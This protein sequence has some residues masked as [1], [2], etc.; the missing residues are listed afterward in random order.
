MALCYLR[1]IFIQWWC[2]EVSLLTL[3]IGIAM[4]GSVKV[5]A[6]IPIAPQSF[7]AKTVVLANPLVERVYS[8]VSGGEL[9]LTYQLHPHATP[10]QKIS[11]DMQINRLGTQIN[12]FI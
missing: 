9:Y 4:E 1:G 2:K 5:C 6:S 3:F 7:I 10:I 11:V 8:A 12:E